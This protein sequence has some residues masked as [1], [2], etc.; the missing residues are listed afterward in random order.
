MG[1]FDR[2]KDLLGRKPEAVDGAVDKAADLADDKT[3]GEYTE[4]I[5]KGAD[6]AKDKA[7]EYLKDDGE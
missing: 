4:Q 6:I 3:G 7:D 2:A 1:I 5:D